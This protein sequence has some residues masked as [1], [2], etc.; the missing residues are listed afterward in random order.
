MCI[1]DSVRIPKADV[2]VWSAEDLEVLAGGT[3]MLT[4]KGH[5][6]VT[7]GYIDFNLLVAA[8]ERVSNPTS[9]ITGRLLGYGTQKMAQALPCAAAQ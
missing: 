9:Q 7:A 6:E 5:V 8:A 3:P 2:G 4:R 1:R